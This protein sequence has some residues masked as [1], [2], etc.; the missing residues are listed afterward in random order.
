MATQPCCQILLL[1]T[2]WPAPL[3]APTA[4]LPTPLPCCP[5]R[6]LRPHH[7]IRS[8]GADTGTTG[9]DQ[10]QFL[11]CPKAQRLLSKVWAGMRTFDA[12]HTEAGWSRVL[13]LPGTAPS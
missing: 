6:S 1:L 12:Q 5:L 7:G 9:G 4:A 13:S 8:Q 3:P 11:A 10:P 2:A